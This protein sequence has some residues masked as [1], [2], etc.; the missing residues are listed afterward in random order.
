MV[1]RSSVIMSARLLIQG[2]PLLIIMKRLT[3]NSRF[4]TGLTNKGEYIQMALTIGVNNRI[5]S[6]HLRWCCFKILFD[7]LVFVKIKLK[8]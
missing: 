1:Y 5:P 4:N 6:A 3:L 8:L 2:D 7:A